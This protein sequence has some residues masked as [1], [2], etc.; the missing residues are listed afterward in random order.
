MAEDWRMDMKQNKFG[1]TL[2][3]LLVLISLLSH[4]TVLADS[5]ESEVKGIL[6]TTAGYL[7]KNVNKPE[8][9]SIGGEWTVIGLA[10]S[11]EDIPEEYFSGY[12][13][14]LIHT[15]KECNG[16]LHDKKYTEYSRTALAVTAIGADPSD[17][18]GYNL[19]APLSDY[20]KTVW[21]GTN[22][23]IWA[24]I[25]LD[26]FDYDITDAKEGTV[27]T[28]RELLIKK[29]ISM[30][31]QNGG[32]SLSEGGRAD[33]DIT[34]MSLTALAPYR[35]M[36]N[37][38]EAIN[39]GLYALSEMQSGNGGFLS[40]GKENCESTAQAL[41]A[42]STLGISA[43]DERFVKNSNSVYDALMSFYLNGGFK[44]TAD[45]R[46][47]NLMST[48]QAL[49]ALAA[50]QR[51]IDGKN[52][53]YDMS[54]RTAAAF[55]S[56]AGIPREDSGTV[57]KS[58]VIYKGKTFSDITELKSR[59]AIEAL[60]ERGI[61]AGKT[62]NE[63]KPFDKMTRAEFAAIS[64]RAVGIRQLKKDCF[65]DVGGS[66][67][68]YGYI[69]AA[70]ESGIINGI[71]EKL[72]N[73]QG[74]ITRA[75]ALTMLSRT[76]KICGLEPIKTV[77]EARDLLAVF[78][79]Y[80]ELPQWAQ[81]PAATCIKYKIYVSAAEEIKPNEKITREEIAQMIYNMLSAC[82]LL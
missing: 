38:S 23:A 16:V 61:I 12:Y 80:A 36:K 21:Q 43:E 70:F 8:V 4:T 74:T 32:F 6:N 54:D 67:W 51:K 78:Y 1:N 60:A 39:K 77:S 56:N 69:G 71:S 2:V 63:F 62:E 34:A 40:D 22:G 64:V 72:F 10:R 73:P 25:A 49:C 15:L 29:I 37:A 9:G 53:I 81:L 3:Y 76:A 59:Q 65:D 26:S 33:A 18:G 30:Q 7:Y 5:R 14:R 20:E 24:L 75:E 28:T 57:K 31:N 11:G 27:K 41:I 19:L 52:P 66:D 82:D 58:E 50:Y 46:E 55:V 45:D 35:D 17:V 42:L 44:H 68:Y 79:D 47:V 13:N 48:E